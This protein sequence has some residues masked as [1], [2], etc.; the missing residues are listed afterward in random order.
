ME[1]ATRRFLLR[2]FVQSD[3]SA[4]LDYQ[5]DPRSLA[6]YGP[7]ESNPDHAIRLF[8]MFQAWACDRPRLNYQ[9]AIVQ[10]YEPYALIGCCGL[11]GLSLATGEMELGLELAPT[12]WGR[13][14]YAIEVGRALLDFGFGELQLDVISGPTVSANTRIAKLA[15]WVGAEVVSIRPGAAWM[16]DRGWSE[17]NWRI[18]R[19]QWNKSGGEI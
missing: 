17:V 15:E 16:R 6:F 2:D 5:A 1:L 10:R 3:R 4:F 9:L 8:E 7:V 14:A 18:T 11:R 13:Y 12:Y 19:E